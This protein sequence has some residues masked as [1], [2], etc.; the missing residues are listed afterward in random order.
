MEAHR[1]LLFSSCPW[2]ATIYHYHYHYHH[3]FKCKQTDW[4]CSRPAT[5]TSVT[6]ILW[7]KLLDSAVGAIEMQAFVLLSISS[8]MQS[9]CWHLL[10]FF[11]VEKNSPT[12]RWMQFNR[13]V[14]YQWTG[15]KRPHEQNKKK[16]MANG[17]RGIR[18]KLMEFGSNRSPMYPLETSFF[19]YTLFSLSLSLYFSIDPTCPVYIIYWK[20]KHFFGHIASAVEGVLNACANDKVI[21]YF[22]S[23][24]LPIFFFRL[25]TIWHLHR[26]ISM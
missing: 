11:F 25:H 8:A 24:N 19:N 3:I 5:L 9:I 26:L 17:T 22:A 16:Q 6:Q 10:L 20:K 1:F 13:F 18:I 21:C 7:A 23:L 15:G 12:F 4:C 2:A 14:R